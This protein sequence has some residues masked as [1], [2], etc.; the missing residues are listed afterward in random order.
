MSTTTITSEKTILIYGLSG[1]QMLALSSMAEK[2]G[3][4]CKAV[5]DTQTTL[6]VAQ[7][8]SENLLPPQPTHPLIGKFALL[9][10]FDGH[11]QI[12]TALINQAAS[13]V[14]KAMHTKHNS[15]WRFCD[16]CSEIQK[17]YQTMKRI[18]TP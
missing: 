9:H 1:M 5:S 7:L 4:V 3:I 10:G 15:N 6:T 16:L 8:L 2:E 17:E 18:Q 14:I 11:P 12:G 13:G